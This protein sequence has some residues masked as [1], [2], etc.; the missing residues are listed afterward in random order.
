MSKST[1]NLDSI[2]LLPHVED[3]KIVIVKAK[4]NESFNNEI[5]Q[6]CKEELL[7]HKI[8][9]ENISV[10][11][12]PGAFEIPFI[13][14][15]IG[16]YQEDVDLIIAIATIIKGETYHFELVANEAT[17]GIMEVMLSHDIPII[18]G[19]LAVNNEEQA[20]VRASRDKENK[21]KELALSAIMILKTRL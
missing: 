12:V 21:G 3:L 17:R 2:S 10:V 16:A 11:E 20:S 1:P 9:K 6:S 8:R 13:A 5:L 14:N 7:R 19:I 18:N 15:Q 4:W